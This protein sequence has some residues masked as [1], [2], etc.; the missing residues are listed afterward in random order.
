MTHLSQRLQKVY[1]LNCLL[2]PSAS[3]PSHLYRWA[4]PLQQV[5]RRE[6]GGGDDFGPL[7]LVRVVA[8]EEKRGSTVLPWE[9]FSPPSCSASSLLSQNSR[10]SFSQ[11]MP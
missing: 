6:E 11:N 1:S 10:S 2:N 3:S 9:K 8:E 4:Q 7:K 5:V